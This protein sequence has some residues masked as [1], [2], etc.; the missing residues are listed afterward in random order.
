MSDR[1]YTTLEVRG[2]NAVSAEKTAIEVLK[3]IKRDD[4]RGKWFDKNSP[5][6]PEPHFFD[7]DSGNAAIVALKSLSLQFPSE[8]FFL[9]VDGGVGEGVQ[10]DVDISN[11][12]VKD[13]RSVEYAYGLPEPQD[14][15]LD[16]AG[17]EAEREEK[18]SYGEVFDPS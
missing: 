5:H 13:G 18:E 17:L 16:P 4:S 9:H 11:G 7:H 12:V 3:A 15:P 2:P 6:N 10:G 1:F 8:T 14:F